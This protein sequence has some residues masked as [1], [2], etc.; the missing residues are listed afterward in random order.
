MRIVVRHPLSGLTRQQY[1][2]GSATLSQ[3]PVT[4]DASRSLRRE[5]PRKGASAP[6][7]V[8]GDPLGFAPARLRHARWDR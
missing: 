5:V 3:I 2:T 7:R 6:P 1:D 8:L 4:S